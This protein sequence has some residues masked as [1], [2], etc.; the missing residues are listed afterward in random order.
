VDRVAGRAAPLRRARSRWRPGDGPVAWVGRF[1][2]PA[3]QGILDAVS[4]ADFLRETELVAVRTPLR[5]IWGA[6]DRLLPEGTLEFFRRALPR[7]EVVVLEDAGH[8][9]H[10]ETPRALARALLAP[11]RS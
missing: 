7:A 9:P 11:F 2:A 5:L 6:H 4:E 8:L 10:I 1:A 3:C